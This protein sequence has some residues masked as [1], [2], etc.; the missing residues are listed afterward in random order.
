MSE[1]PWPRT[2]WDLDKEAMRPE[3]RVQV[4]DWI[5]RRY[6]E[7]RQSH[8]PERRRIRRAK[9]L[10][11]TERIVVCGPKIPYSPAPCNQCGE[12]R[13]A[14]SVGGRCKAC[15]IAKAVQTRMARKAARTA[16]PAD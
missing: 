13:D 6:L 3:D 9:P 11:G 2:L 8:T 14:R 5:A 4:Q 16:A 7:S 12:P 10:L 15:G 1:G